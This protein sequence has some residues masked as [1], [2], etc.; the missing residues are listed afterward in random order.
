M[1]L[2]RKDQ[3]ALLRGG[4]GLDSRHAVSQFCNPALEALDGHLHCV[5]AREAVR[6]QGDSCPAVVNED[7]SCGMTNWQV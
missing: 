6:A 1:P 7:L 5:L 2:F 3:H 4:S